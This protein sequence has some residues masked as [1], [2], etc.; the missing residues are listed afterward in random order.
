MLRWNGSNGII[1]LRTSRKNILETLSCKCFASF[2]LN[3]HK[4]NPAYGR[5]RISWPMRIVGPIHFWRGC[6]IYLR[7]GGRGRPMRGWD[8]IMWPEGHGKIKSKKKSI[9][10]LIF[11][12]MKIIFKW[13]KSL[14]IFKNYIFVTKMANTSDFSCQKC[15]KIVIFFSDILHGITLKPSWAR[16]LGYFW[17]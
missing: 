11:N 2:G 15:K 3:R 6:V 10:N 8:L 1:I 16:F 4:K 12:F 5:Q 13:S 9:K 7:G 14:N 17:L